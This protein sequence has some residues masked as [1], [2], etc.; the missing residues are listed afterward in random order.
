MF[1]LFWITRAV[2]GI[3]GSTLNNN[4]YWNI[5][6]FY[7]LPAYGEWRTFDPS[8]WLG[9]FGS[10]P[11][12][13]WCPQCSVRRRINCWSSS[14]TWSEMPTLVKSVFFVGNEST[15]VGSGFIGLNDSHVRW[16]VQWIQPC[17][18]LAQ[19]FHPLFLG[20]SD[21]RNVKSMLLA[22]HSHLRTS[23]AHPGREMRES[24][25]D[26]VSYSCP[27]QPSS[28]LLGWMCMSSGP[29]IL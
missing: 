16:I 13:R 1:T 6:C 21:K 25:D 2:I 29:L 24:P 15:T 17:R 27:V 19:D 28:G 3:R 9:W 5:F 7:H 12:A 20:R 18:P 14:W 26:E 11:L 23:I 22:T 8:E 4:Y 10:T